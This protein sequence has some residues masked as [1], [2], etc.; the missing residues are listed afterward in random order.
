MKQSEKNTSTVPRFCPAGVFVPAR[1]TPRGDL[2]PADRRDYGHGGGG[3]WG[4]E[5]KARVGGQRQRRAGRCSAAVAR[6]TA[7]R[8]GWV[9]PAPKALA[10]FMV[11]GGVAG[12]SCHRCMAAW[13]GYTLL[14]PGAGQ[15]SVFCS[16]ENVIW[17]LTL[18]YSENCSVCSGEFLL[19]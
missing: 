15:Y 11:G 16:A 19:N 8:H 1:G 18:E 9:R 4:A 10:Y 13:R 6:Q 17:G 2:Q 14:N 5:R 3:L 12:P 7:L